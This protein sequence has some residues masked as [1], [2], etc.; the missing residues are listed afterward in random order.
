[1]GQKKT[2]EEQIIRFEQKQN[3]WLEPM[4]EWINE[5]A[6][7]AKIAR[8]NDLFAKKVLASKIFGSNLV[9]ENKKARGSA[10]NQWAAQ[11]A[12]HNNV[13][14]I[15]KSQ[16]LAPLIGIEPIFQ[17]PETCVLSIERQGQ[18]RK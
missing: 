14:K 4:R 6:K 18:K 5:A 15:P 7:A 2:L 13:N 3:D 11:S 8:D 9:L 16:L 1:M 12:A 10:Q 17:V